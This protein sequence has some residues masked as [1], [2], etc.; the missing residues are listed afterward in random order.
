[1]PSE[2]P[3]LASSRAKISPMTTC[4]KF[5][6]SRVGFI[7]FLLFA[8]LHIVFLQ[9]KQPAGRK[10]YTVVDGPT[11]DHPF[12]ANESPRVDQYAQNIT[13]HRPSVFVCITG[14]VKRLVGTLILESILKPL[15]QQGYHVDLALVL[16]ENGLYS[17]NDNATNWEWS[18]FQS[19]QE[20][21]NYFFTNNI[22]VVT[23]KPIVQL[24]NPP[25]P[26]NYL[27]RMDK[28]WESLE[29]QQARVQ[30]HARQF[31][32]LS[33]CHDAMTATHKQYNFAIRLREDVALKQ[34][35]NMTE[36]LPVLYP[37]TALTRILG[38][39]TIVG[40]DC[41]TFLGIND[42]MAI[43]SHD[44]FQDY[45]RGP[46]KYF[47]LHDSDLAIVPSNSTSMTTRSRIHVNNPE[48]FLWHVYRHR[49]KLHVVNSEKLRGVTKYQ[50]RNRG[51]REDP[52]L[53]FEEGPREKRTLCPGDGTV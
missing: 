48:T 38:N 22:H 47:H 1:M 21:V 41:R 35:I 44:A 36:L 18:Q 31:H 25:I 8:V 29:W 49:L 12:A 34:P 39:K 5:K 11:L 15:Q 43:V 27:S 53:V 14:Q 3:R 9:N 2:S 33:K 42:R 4:S 24:S 20:A 26:P 52:R 6:L 17:T 45:F 46:W 13:R 10:Q 37:P 19:F 40:T 7:C 50:S 16:S 23:L 51:T 30:N 32:T 28:T